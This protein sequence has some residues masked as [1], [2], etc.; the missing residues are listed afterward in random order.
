MERICILF[1]FYFLYL[2]VSVPNWLSHLLLFLFVIIHLI[3][4][5]LH[6]YIMKTTIRTSLV[7][8]FLVRNWYYTL[9]GLRSMIRRYEILRNIYIKVAVEIRLILSWSLQLVLLT[10]IIL[11]IESRFHRPIWLDLLMYQ[12]LALTLRVMSVL[13]PLNCFNLIWNLI[14]EERKNSFQIFKVRVILFAT[15]VNFKIKTRDDWIIGTFLKHLAILI[16]MQQSFWWNF[17]TTFTFENISLSKKIL[18]IAR[19]SSKVSLDSSLR[20]LK[21][22]ARTTLVRKILLTR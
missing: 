21:L 16:M 15:F 8:S 12:I 1:Y 11:I 4:F 6:I 2:H 17:S 9:V 5:L 13:L 22:I 14:H 7:H 3:I 19:D 10:W 18:W 20:S